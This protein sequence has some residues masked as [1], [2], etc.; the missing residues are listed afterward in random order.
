MTPA[1]IGPSC[2][3]VTSLIPQNGCSLRLTCLLLLD[4]PSLTMTGD[5]S[6]QFSVK[7]ECRDSMFNK[8]IRQHIYQAANLLAKTSTGALDS[9][10][11]ISI[12][13]LGVHMMVWL[14]FAAKAMCEVPPRIFLNLIRFLLCIF[15]HIYLRNLQLLMLHI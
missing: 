7:C 15:E 2:V 8:F 13:L 10:F 14:Y 5:P 6:T 9:I 11:A 12:S 4:Q 1:V 3:E